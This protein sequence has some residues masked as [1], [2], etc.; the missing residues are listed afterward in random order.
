[1][2][3]EDRS[4]SGISISNINVANQPGEAVQPGRRFSQGGGLAGEAHSEHFFDA[5]TPVVAVTSAI[6]FNPYPHGL[7][8]ELK[9]TGGAETAPPL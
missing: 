9:P 5:V 2:N 4:N 7:L 1:M 8:N 3:A 6:D